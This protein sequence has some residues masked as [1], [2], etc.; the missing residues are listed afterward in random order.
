MHK[1]RELE[2]KWLRD[3]GVYG[4]IDENEAV[5]PNAQA[6]SEESITC[7]AVKE[8]R[9]KNIMG[10]VALKKGLQNLG[11]S[12]V[13]RSSL[14]CLVIVRS[15]RRVTQNLQSLRS[16]N[17][18]DVT[19]EDAVKVDKESNGLI[20]NAVMLLR[21]IVRTVKC[22]IESRTQEPLSDESL[23]LPSLVEHMQD[24][25]CPC[26]TKVVTGRRHL[27][28]CTARNRHRNSSR[29]ERRCWQEKLPR[30]R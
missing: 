20:E 10:S 28:D 14:T 27:K 4:K 9:H 25:S 13:W 22:H 15:R 5:A 17:V 16:E 30:I 6:I 8:D 11:Q 21:G 1:A 23:V 29:S 18:A 12:R 3:L 2:L 24:A 19:T 26:V 7:V